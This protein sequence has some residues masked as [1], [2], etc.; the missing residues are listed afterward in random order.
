M[1]KQYPQVFRRTVPHNTTVTGFNED[2]PMSGRQDCAD[3]ILFT[4]TC[5]TKCINNMLQRKSKKKPY[6]ND[7]LFFTTENFQQTTKTH[8]KRSHFLISL[9]TG[10]K[11]FSPKHFAQKTSPSFLFCG[12][13]SDESA[14]REDI[15][16]GCLSQKGVFLLILKGNNKKCKTHPFPLDC[17][18][19]IGSE[20]FPQ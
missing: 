9:C 10:I 19:D 5:Y 15:P 16:A 8:P 18:V 7:L 4:S 13:I 20:F 2:H 17:L 3:G 12:R 11:V 14:V 1:M 6:N